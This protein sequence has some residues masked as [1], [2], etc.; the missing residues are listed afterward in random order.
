M[1]D[2]F[3][4]ATR[5]RIMR[6]LKEDMKRTRY[7]GIDPGV[8]GGIAC[9]TALG[10]IETV[11][12]RPEDDRGLLDMLA[13]VSEGAYAVLEY[14]RS[15]PQMGV[16]SAFTFGR[17]YGEIRMALAAA[18]IPF[19]EVY[20]HKWQATMGCRTKGDKNISKRMAQ[21][22]FPAIKVTHAIADA[23]LLAEYCRRLEV[24]S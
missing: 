4:K 9:I 18:R 17:G 12:K 6:R 15:S 19:E 8:G 2:C 10:N 3:N 21:E 7:I 20:S 1:A 5:S 22:L 23:L 16:T 11:G 14:A 13:A 24:R